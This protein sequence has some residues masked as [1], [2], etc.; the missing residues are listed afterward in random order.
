VPRP[1]NGGRPGAITPRVGNIPRYSHL[2]SGPAIVTHGP[3]RWVGRSPDTPTPDAPAAEW[4]AFWVA[5]AWWA[6]EY[7]RR[8]WGWAA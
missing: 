3:L 7:R 8:E 2:A 4:T 1:P 5:L 6:T